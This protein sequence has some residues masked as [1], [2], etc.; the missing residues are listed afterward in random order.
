MSNLGRASLGKAWLALSALACA[1]LV[2]ALSMRVLLAEIGQPFAGLLAVPTTGGVRVDNGT[3]PW[4]PAMD[5]IT[6]FDTVRSAANTDAFDALVTAA[7]GRGESHLDVD[8]QDGAG[9]IRRAR[10]TIQPFALGHALDVRAIEI[11]NGLTLWLIGVLILRARPSDAF[12]RSVA[13]AC[14]LFSMN[15]W[16]WHGALLRR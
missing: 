6:P 5:A 1:L 13:L 15:Q 2:G 14:A 8:V 4:W 3:P 12:N 7:V 11:L 16:L 10:L 9:A